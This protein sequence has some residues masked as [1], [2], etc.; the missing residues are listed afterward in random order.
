MIGLLLD[1]DATREVLHQ[2]YFCIDNG[3][4][5]E[6]AALFAPDGESIPACSCHSRGSGDLCPRVPAVAGMTDTR[7]HRA[8]HMK[9][10][11]STTRAAGR[12]VPVTGC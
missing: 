1:K 11:V 7:L 3:R 8:P 4:F 12:I 5:T 9:P 2:N 10:A 6:L